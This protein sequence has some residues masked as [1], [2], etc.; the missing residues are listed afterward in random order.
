[1]IRSKNCNTVIPLIS[2]GA[3]GEKNNKNVLKI[4][5]MLHAE[6]IALG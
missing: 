5:K 3:F 4:K 6:K 2:I 1:M